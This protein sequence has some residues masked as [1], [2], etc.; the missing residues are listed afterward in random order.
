MRTESDFLGEIDINEESLF[1][2]HSV[3]A[4]NNFPHKSTFNK[5]WYKAI[6]MV[7]QACFIVAQKYFNELSKKYDVG[8]LGFNIPDES[9]LENLIKSASDVSKGEYF[10]DFIVPAVSGGAGTSINMNINEILCNV[11]L[12]S[13]GYSPGQYKYIDPI[14]DANIFQ[15]TNDVIPTALKVAIMQQLTILESKINELRAAIEDIEKKHLG[16]LRIGYT[17]MQ[18][19]VPNSYGRLFSNY[20]DALSRDWWRVSKCFERIKLVNLGGSALG[21]GLTVPRYFIMNVVQELQSISGLPVTRGDNLTDNTSNLDA[22]VEVHAI[23]K[24]HAVNLEKMVNDLRL[25]SSDIVGKKEIELPKKQIG[26][27]IMPGKVNPVIPEYVISCA[28]KI[29]ANDQL[30]TS[31]SA[32][33]CLDLNAYIPI[34]GDAFL[35]SLELLCSCDETIKDNLISGLVI[36][37]GIAMCE[38]MKSPSITTALIPVIG[39]NKAAE[40]SKYM[41]VNNCDINSANLY[42]KVLSKDKLSSLLSPEYLLNQGY[43]IQDF[44][45]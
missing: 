9:V 13:M 37:K 28:H 25:L 15:S 38:L 33:G 14:E 24:S 1:G 35:N 30:I 11:S 42:L 22:F 44:V 34:I 39:Y 23:I 7:K 17:Q 18:E 6:G 16:A 12:K 43:R 31:L 40:L 21:T 10:N 27:S 32:Q 41:K 3:R 26:S 29:Y 19:A 45:D 36:N 2:I 5:N 4:C 8:K 20:N